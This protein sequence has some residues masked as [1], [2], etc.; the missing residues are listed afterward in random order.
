MDF[1]GQEGVKARV[2]HVTPMRH[3]GGDEAGSG[4]LL[5]SD[6]GRKAG[7]LSAG[8]E[9]V[10]GRGSTGPVVRPIRCLLQNT[11]GRRQ[12]LYPA[13]RNVDPRWALAS[14]VIPTTAAPGLI[15]QVDRCQPL[16]IRPLRPGNAFNLPPAI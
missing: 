4:L 1:S 12:S 9:R 13:P 16:P 11:R 15:W 14:R 6:G 5:W 7:S 8:R 10:H 2:A 3:N